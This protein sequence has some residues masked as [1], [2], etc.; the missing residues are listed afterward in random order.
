MVWAAARQVLQLGPALRSPGASL[1]DTKPFPLASQV[2]AMSGRRSWCFEGENFQH[3][4]YPTAAL[5]QRHQEQLPRESHRGEARDS[6]LE[7]GSAQLPPHPS[8]RT[9]LTA[10]F[11]VSMDSRQAPNVSFV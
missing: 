1:E 3:E 2:W 11:L 7:L 4:L 6:G 8:G 5:G 9:G 10:G